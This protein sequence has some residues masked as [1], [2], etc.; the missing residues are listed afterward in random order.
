MQF[1]GMFSWLILDILI[2]SLFVCFAIIYFIF[3]NG[4]LCYVALAIL[5]HI[6]WIKSSWPQIHPSDR[7]KSM[8]HHEL[9][10]FFI[11]FS[12]CV[13]VVGW[14]HVCVLGAHRSQKVGSFSMR[15]LRAD[16]VLLTTEPS[17]SSASNAFYCFLQV[18]TPCEHQAGLEFVAIY[19]RIA[20]LS[21][22]LQE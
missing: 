13:W 11:L 1:C 9:K 21:A 8:C 22:P 10:I 5:E 19:L 20:V 15:V 14:L 18:W 16:S 6:M 12:F 2:L 7:V 3:R 4:C 17:I